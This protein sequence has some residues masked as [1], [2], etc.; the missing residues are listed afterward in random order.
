MYRTLLGATLFFVA[1]SAGAQQGALKQCAEIE[2]SLERLVCYDNLAK[3]QQ[4]EKA[5]TKVKEKEMTK[6]QKDSGQKAAEQ[7]T[8]NSSEQSFG[9]EHKEK[10]EGQLDRIEVEVV[11]KEK[12]PYKKWRIELA[13]GQV[14]KQTDGPNYFSWSEDDTYFIERGAF[15]SFSF[16][17]EGSNRRMRV[18]RVK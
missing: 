10:E 2:D 9:M 4:P 5:E 3:Q 12:G 16:G 8:K 17:R 15:N 6:K 11:A 7:S 1:S 14:W 13:S 18:Q